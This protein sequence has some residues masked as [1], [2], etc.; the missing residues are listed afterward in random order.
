MSIMMFRDKFSILLPLAMSLSLASLSSIPHLY[1][2][3][4][5]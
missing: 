5:L 2:T 4:F 1:V 3:I